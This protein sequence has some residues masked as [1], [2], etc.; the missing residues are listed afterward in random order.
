MDTYTIAELLARVNRT[1]DIISKDL[2]IIFNPDAVREYYGNFIVRLRGLHVHITDKDVIAAFIPGIGARIVLLPGQK[3]KQFL[4]QGQP[5]PK[6]P[7]LHALIPAPWEDALGIKIVCLTK[8]PNKHLAAR[9]LV[10][11]SCLG[12]NEAKADGIFTI[13]RLISNI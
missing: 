2:A 4:F 12:V 13:W 1:T 11:L 7:K 10:D 9:I 5:P 6:S 8:V 3:H